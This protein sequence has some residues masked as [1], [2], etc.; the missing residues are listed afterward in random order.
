M[1]NPDAKSILFIAPSAY[2]LGGVQTWLDYMLDG[3]SEHDFRTTL[4]LP[5]GKFHDSNLYL[6]SHPF[7]SVELL[8]NHTGSI[9]GRNQ[10]LQNVICKVDPEV[11][12]VVNI[13]D[14]Y[15]SVNELRALGKTRAKVVTTL[16]GI[17]PG[18]INDIDQCSDVIDGVIST[19]RLT[20]KLVNTKTKIDESRSY[21]APYGVLGGNLARTPQRNFTIAYVGRFEET[22]KCIDDLLLIFQKV[23]DEQS[24]VTILLAGDGPDLDKFEAWFTK[25]GKP[26]NVKYLG[27][28]PPEELNRQ[29]YAQSNVLLLT[30]SWETGP[31]VAWEAIQNGVTLVS[32]RYIGSIEEG[33]LKHQENC[34][35]FDIGDIKEAAQQ[36]KQARSPKLRAS[37]NKNA[38]TL[39]EN[40]YSINRSLK[41]WAECLTIIAN[42][43]TRKHVANL[44]VN[45]DRGFITDNMFRLFGKR[46]LRLTESIR[47]IVNAS[48]DHAEAGSEW[49]HCGRNK[50]SDRD[51]NALTKYVE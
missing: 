20:Q 6:Q 37:L 7:K 24:D 51:A 11:I 26:Q 21:Y 9:E 23:I 32:S 40:K 17:H 30:S 28:L 39:V 36:L 50:D 46:G 1:T 41:K 22:Q 48:F 45:R 49:P 25:L 42:R 5:D 33:S 2:S 12:L 8:V 29:V 31:I 18:L 38:L 27:V 34:L 3:L 47:R 4:A 44:V 14:V 13:F 16:H 15:R 10:A 43:D 19:N 35:M